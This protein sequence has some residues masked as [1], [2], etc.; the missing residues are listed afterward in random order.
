M[1]ILIHHPFLYLGPLSQEL[2][3]NRFPSTL[4]V[5]WPC[6]LLWPMQCYKSSVLKLTGMSG[7]ALSLAPLPQLKN[8]LRLVC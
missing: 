5:G 1:M 7:L 3:S 8:K 4:N 2:E 6:E